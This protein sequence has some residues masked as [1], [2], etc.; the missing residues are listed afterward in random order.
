MTETPQFEPFRRSA[1][2]LAEHAYRRFNI[3]VPSN[4]PEEA[5]TDYRL[6]VNVAEKINAGDE[7]RVLAED[8]SFR[9]L[10][11]AGF[12]DRANVRLHLLEFNQIEIPIDDEGFE[13]EYEIKL[14]GTEKFCII[15]KE[16]GEVIQSGIPTKA[17]ALAALEEYLDVLTR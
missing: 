11:V 6:Y 1:L 13:S 12:A 9:A 4:L 5:L 17:K 7:I 15:R 14:R 2:Q 3:T 8:F 10:L 16:D